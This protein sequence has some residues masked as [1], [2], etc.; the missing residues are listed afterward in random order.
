LVLE[1]GLAD[2]FVEKIS[3]YSYSIY[4]C[5][6]PLIFIVRHAASVGTESAGATVFLAILVW[7]LAVYFV[8]ALVFHTFEKPVSD[9]RERFTRRISTLPF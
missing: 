6:F 5:H 7:L 4:L 3:L 2:R 8:S 9:L 1:R